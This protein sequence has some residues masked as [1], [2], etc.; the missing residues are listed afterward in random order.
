MQD[1]KYYHMKLSKGIEFIESIGSECSS[2]SQ[3]R[4]KDFFISIAGISYN[5][6]S[7]YN[8]T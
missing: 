4:L 3:N 5:R 2:L 7:D 6:K 8:F 1:D